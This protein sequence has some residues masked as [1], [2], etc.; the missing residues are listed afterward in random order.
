MGQ[1]KFIEKFQNLN[2]LDIGFF[3]GYRTG[4]EFLKFAEKSFLEVTRDRRIGKLLHA[5]E[6]AGELL[7]NVDQLKE[8]KDKERV[9]GVDT[10]FRQ[11]NQFT[12]GFQKNN[13]ISSYI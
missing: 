12:H 11:L 2:K 8:C 4:D 5:S 13:F 10:G 9:T 1:T 7:S 3:D 6:V